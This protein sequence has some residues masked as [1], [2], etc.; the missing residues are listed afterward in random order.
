MRRGPGIAFHTGRRVRDGRIKGAILPVDRIERS[1]SL[2]I[3]FFNRKFLWMSLSRLFEIYN[4]SHIFGVMHS[5]SSYF[6]EI[7]FWSHLDEE[8]AT[9]PQLFHIHGRIES[10]KSE[11]ERS[12]KNEL[13][14]WSGSCSVSEFE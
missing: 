7:Y 3:D 8:W 6:E 1:I 5:M 14:T 11:N 2:K 13:E 4:F 9:N 12:L 10:I